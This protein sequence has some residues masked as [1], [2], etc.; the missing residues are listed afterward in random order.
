MPKNNPIWPKI[1]IF[2]YCWLI[3][4]PVGGL[5]GGCGARAISRETPI[6]FIEVKV[7]AALTNPNRLQSVLSFTLL[8][9]SFYRIC[10]MTFYDVLVPFEASPSPQPNAQNSATKKR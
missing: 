10:D 1:G 2:V 7:D 5:A 6:F 4:C 9:G 8:F 3:W